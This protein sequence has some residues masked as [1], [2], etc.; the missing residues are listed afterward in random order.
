MALHLNQPF[1]T[2]WYEHYAEVGHRAGGGAIPL[3]SSCGD[4]LGTLGIAGYGES[5][6]PRL[7]SLLA[8]AAGILEEKIRHAEELAHFAVLQEFNRACS[9]YPESLLLALC[10]HGRIL[11]LSQSLAKLVT[12]QL[13][14]RLIG[15]S[16][17]DVRDFHLEGLCPS[18]GSNSSEPY[19]SLL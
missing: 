7:F 9:R 18:L 14:E 5:A 15:R 11:A 17:H 19:E 1:Q 6:H 4:M 13:P 2:Y 12:L 3:R 10:P 8:F 16:L